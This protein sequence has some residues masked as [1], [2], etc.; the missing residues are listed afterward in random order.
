MDCADKGRDGPA[1]VEVPD[2]GVFQM[3]P[4]CGV[5]ADIWTLPASLWKS[6]TM[7]R[8]DHTR[9]YIT[10]LTGVAEKSF[11]RLPTP[12]TKDNMSRSSLDKVAAIQQL[13]RANDRARRKSDVTAKEAEAIL[14]NWKLLNIENQYPVELLL[15]IVG[16]AIASI[17]LAAIQFSKRKLRCQDTEVNVLELTKRVKT[18]EMKLEGRGCPITSESAIA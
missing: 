1:T 17:A 11:I 5:G 2:F 14:E 13:L 18:I 7:N 8:S 3:P 15:G 4:G 12:E 16:L 9:L 10:N 6:I